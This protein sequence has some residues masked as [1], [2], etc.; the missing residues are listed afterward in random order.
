MPE[1]DFS[2]IERTR[3]DDVLGTLNRINIFD[4]W[5]GSVEWGGST[6]TLHFYNVPD[7][8]LNERIA[9]ARNLWQNLTAVDAASR[10]AAFEA[11]ESWNDELKVEWLGQDAKFLTDAKFK[12]SMRLESA[13]FEGGLIELTYDDGDLFGG[14]AITVTL[15]P[16]LTVDHAELLG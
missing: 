16:D 5:E 7:D 4:Q 15:N 13:S 14:H 2:K 1:K 12:G 6:V 9:M 10:Q 11:F 8:E 3:E